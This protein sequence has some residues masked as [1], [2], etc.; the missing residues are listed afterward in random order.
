M[1]RLS[2]KKTTTDHASIPQILEV[3]NHQDEA[4]KLVASAIAEN[5]V[6]MAFQPVVSA[7]NQK[8]PAF[9]ECLVRIRERNGDIVPAARFMP[10]V[11]HCDLGRLVDRQTLRQVVTILK[12]TQRVR[13]SINI[14]ANTIGDEEWLNILKKAC[15]VSPA[16]GEFLIVEITESALLDL[17]DDNI[18]FLNQLRQLGCSIAIDDFGSGHTSIG[19]LGRF[20][21][22][23]LKIDGSYIRELETNA[24]NQFLVRSMLSIARHFEMVSVAEMVE[25]DG[26]AEILENMGVDCLQG[27][28]FGKPDTSPVWLKF[29]D[30]KSA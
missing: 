5:R 30:R 11:E 6:T 22:D 4:V 26:T 8:V 15:T 23:I 28:H 2:R 10:H 12:R 13:L 24:D 16:C 19:Q 18:E 27:Y 25:N 17:N 3:T 20:R 29:E 14:S 7:A 21:F 9:Q 1:F